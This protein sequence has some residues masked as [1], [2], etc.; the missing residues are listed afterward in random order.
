LYGIVYVVASAYA[1]V[2]ERSEKSVS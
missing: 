2:P 1:G